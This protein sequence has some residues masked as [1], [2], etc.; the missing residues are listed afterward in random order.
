MKH[1]Y[2]KTYILVLLLVTGGLYTSYAQ[3]NKVV[4]VSAN[5]RPLKDVLNNLEKQG[6]F[7]FSYNSNIIKEDSIVSVAAQG[8]TVKQVLDY[9]FN[10]TVEYKETGKHIILQHSIAGS[11]WYVSGYITDG[12]TGER[13]ANVSVYEKRQLVASMTNEQ[14]FFRLRLKDRQQPAIIS[15]S[16]SW[17]ADTTIAIKAGYDQELTVSI[18][19]KAIDL[20]SIVVTPYGAVDKNWLANL[21]LSS[22]QRMQSLNM[23]KF[24]VDKPYQ[25]S[26]VPGVGTHGKMSGQVVNDFS[27]NV[28]GGYTAGVSG[29]EIGGLFNIVK[30]NVDG[31][32]IAGVFNVAGGYVNGLQIAGLYNG[33]MDSMK[34]VQIA[35]LSNMANK[36]VRGIQVCGLY[37]YANGSVD[38]T[39]VS[40]LANFARDNVDGAQ[41]SGL[42]NYTGD[43]VSGTQVSGLF[44]IAGKEID[45]VQVSGL[46]NYSRR[47][48]GAQIGVINISDTSTGYSIGLI[49]FVRKGYHKVSF[50]TNELTNVNV[51]FRNGNRRLYSI[52]LGGMN[53]SDQQKLYTFGYGVGFDVRLGKRISLLPE[54]TSEYVY[55]GRW[56][57]F[58]SLTKI[59]LNIQFTINKYIAVYAGPSFALYIPDAG[60]AAAGYKEIMPAPGYGT[61]N[62]APGNSFWIGWQ[63]GIS[64]F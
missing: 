29:F 61:T 46:L 43:N 36:G 63:A 12:S 62:V 60:M 26:V 64:L 41:V 35:G 16:K 20:D 6:G 30:M 7:Y 9:L 32:Q 58:N 55:K 59:H 19:P 13:M 54:F 24:F 51:S 38:G 48:E 8:K 56:D 10:G 44:N 52:L 42:F 53:I 57:Q 18:A 3:L 14:G 47:L 1:F 4:S 33:I 28:L 22:R 23:G 17:Y 21:F 5:R 39:Q 11:Y 2:T 49:N 25:A 50:S 31:A 37:N 45:G 15:V 40:G 27:F 34:G